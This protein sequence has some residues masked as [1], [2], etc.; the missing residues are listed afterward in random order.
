VYRTSSAAPLIHCLLLVTSSERWQPLPPNLIS[1]PIAKKS[2][3]LHSKAG[4]ANQNDREKR[5]KTGVTD[6]NF[7][8]RE[9][10]KVVHR[11][12]THRDGDS[13]IVQDKGSIGNGNL[14]DRHD[15]VA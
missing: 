2:K 10:R 7:Q 11:S 5:Q 15:G 14:G 3:M 9:R 6:G 12:F 4:T 8:R 13:I 1:W